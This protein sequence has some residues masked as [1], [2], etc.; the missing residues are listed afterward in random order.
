MLSQNTFWAVL[1]QQVDT[2]SG[3]VDTS[4]FPRTPSGLFWDSRSTR[5]QAVSTRVAFPE[6][7][8]WSQQ[9]KQ[10]KKNDLVWMIS[11]SPATK[12][13][14][15]R[16]QQASRARFDEGLLSSGRSEGRKKVHQAFSC[17]AENAASTYVA[18]YRTRPGVVTPDQAAATVSRLWWRTRLQDVAQPSVATLSEHIQPPTVVDAE[19]MKIDKEFVVYADRWRALAAKVRCPMPEEEKVKLIIANA[20]PTY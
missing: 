17:I 10:G 11:C 2:G 13:F 15:T 18:T 1:G 20:T 7:S 8:T 3:C 9:T 16:S 12:N 14:S 4:G 19:K 5:A 6:Q